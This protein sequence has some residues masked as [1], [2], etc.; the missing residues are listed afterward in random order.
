VRLNDE[1]REFLERR[2]EA[3][4]GKAGREGVIEESSVERVQAE[5]LAPGSI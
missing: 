4:F 3:E 2:D 5:C 1:C